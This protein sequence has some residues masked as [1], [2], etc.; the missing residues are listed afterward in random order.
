MKM[1]GKLA[2][3]TQETH[4]GLFQIDLKNGFK[5][6]IGAAVLRQV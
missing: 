4:V 6:V 5:T 3:S 2:R 1:E